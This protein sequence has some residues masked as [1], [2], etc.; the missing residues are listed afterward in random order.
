MR[1]IL[2][3][4]LLVSPLLL[5]GCAQAVADAQDLYQRGRMAVERN[6]MFRMDSRE[7]CRQMVMEDVNMYRRD[8]LLKEQAGDFEDATAS[9]AKAA[10]I[11]KTNFPDLV[12]VQGLETI[13][14]TAETDKLAKVFP[15]KCYD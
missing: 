14:E 3:I 1:P 12:T 6:H 13:I 2:L 15:L 7:I 10:A 8:A 5:G 4:P 11:L 9:R